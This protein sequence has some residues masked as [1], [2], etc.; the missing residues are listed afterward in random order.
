MLS[1]LLS[2]ALAVFF[3][4]VTHSQ[5]TEAWCWKGDVVKQSEFPF[6]RALDEKYVL[7]WRIERGTITFA[8][9]VEGVYSFIGLGITQGGMNGADLWV[10]RSDDSAAWLA[11]KWHVN[12]FYSNSS[13]VN[14]VVDAQ[15]D[16]RMIDVQQTKTFTMLELQR[17]LD[18]CDRLQDQYIYND[19]DV[20]MI[21]AYGSK[22]DLSMWQNAKTKP[23]RLN[24]TN[25]S[26]VNET[27]TTSSYYLQLYSRDPP[28]LTAL[29]LTVNQYTVS[30]AATSYRCV[31][32]DAMSR[33]PSSDDEDSRHFK[34]HIIRYNGVMRA[35][36]TGVGSV[37]SLA[38]HMVLYGCSQPHPAAR[39]YSCTTPPSYCSNIFAFWTPSTGNV[40]LPAE[41]GLPLGLNS[42]NYFTLMVHYSNPQGLSNVIDS[43]G[44]MLYFTRQLRANDAAV[45][46]LGTNNITVTSPNAPATV[47]SGVCP[48]SCSSKQVTNSSNSLIMF[49]NFFRM[50]GAGASI[51]TRHIRNGSEIMPLGVRNFWNSS[52]QYSSTVFPESRLLMPGDSLVTTCTYNTAK[53][54]PGEEVCQNLVMYFPATPFTDCTTYV[55]SSLGAYQ[56]CGPAEVA[57]TVSNA[58]VLS[59]YLQ[60]G[61]LLSAEA[62]PTYIPYTQPCFKFVPPPHTYY[63]GAAVGTIVALTIVSLAIIAFLYFRYARF[64]EPEQQ[65]ILEELQRRLNAAASSSAQEDDV[66]QPQFMTNAGTR[67]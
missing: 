11:Q 28:D 30:K 16:I 23:I 65:A 19:T 47:T 59:G 2:V 56:A 44:F 36:Q 3:V 6:C 46:A 55:N 26:F 53:L 13:F 7:H 4:P 49:A 57:A 34:Y 12:D 25:F 31:D 35:L 54:R 5:D 64:E 14:P 10:A 32:F 39:S 9:Y 27:N 1:I 61:T 33:I 29:E 45:L 51:I 62:L 17:D 42:Y 38:H 60:N 20:N 48:A 63:V 24:P 40:S 21:W 18:T 15:Q 22:Y 50:N 52:I 67:G 58:T 43:S 41:A 66:A 8:V 37:P